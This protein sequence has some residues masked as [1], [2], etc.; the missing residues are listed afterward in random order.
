MT[1]QY[2][3]KN[4]KNSDI[5]DESYFSPG[6]RPHSVEIMRTLDLDESFIDPFLELAPFSARSEKTYDE[7]RTKVEHRQIIGN[8]PI[9]IDNLKAHLPFLATHLQEALAESVSA[10]NP[11]Q[12][13]SAG[14]RPGPINTNLSPGFHE[15]VH[16]EHRSP[17][18]PTPNISSV[19]IQH[20]RQERRQQQQQK[21]CTVDD[22]PPS[23]ELCHNTHELQHHICQENIE[24]LQN[25]LLDMKH[26]LQYCQE[27]EKTKEQLLEESYN[28]TRQ[29]QESV[30]NLFQQVGERENLL[31]K[32]SLEVNKLKNK[33]EEVISQRDSFQNQTKELEERC[34]DLHKK[35]ENNANNLTMM[36][37]ERDELLAKLKSERENIENISEE[38][39][40][41]IMKM[42]KETSNIREKLDLQIGRSMQLEAELARLKSVNAQLESGIQE[43]TKQ[44]LSNAQTSAAEIRSLQEEKQTAY[45]SH[46]LEINQ[47]KKELNQLN[48]EN[49]EYKKEISRLQTK[50]N[51]L[52]DEVIQCR[53][54]LQVKTNI[55]EEKERQIH[56][57]TH[58]LESCHRELETQ[59][60]SV[61]LFKSEQKMIQNSFEEKIKQ[62]EIIDSQK[63]REVENLSM[64]LNQAK[65]FLPT[66]TSN[67]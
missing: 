18:T 17:P 60:N 48:N 23:C 39:K 47:I 50:T 62:L 59:I 42:L 13:C 53:N 12:C 45:N 24:Y 55:V 26:Q 41:Q 66:G 16:C 37:K 25:Q 58:E 32:L 56:S 40:R 46:Q 43:M 33:H 27:R 31:H 28:T 35:Y 22:S 64:D 49:T 5:I 6:Q 38:R 51:E 4:E 11:N 14:Q 36:V 44:S 7:G 57:L 21:T 67:T 63:Q 29:L 61:G 1:D 2:R 10:G 30:T 54:N 19:A 65:C 9:P 52:K 3:G 8:L 20:I 34:H 15:S